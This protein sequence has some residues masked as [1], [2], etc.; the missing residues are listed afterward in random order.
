MIRVSTIW[1]ATHVRIM[2]LRS[3]VTFMIR[4]RRTRPV[5]RPFDR[6][7]TDQ[8]DRVAPDPAGQ[9]NRLVVLMHVYYQDALPRLIELLHAIPARFDLVITNSSG[10]PLLLPDDLPGELDDLRILDVRN[11]GRDIW[12]MVQV[13]NDG[14]I[15]KHDLVLKVHTKRSAWRDRHSLA[16]TGAEWNE[17]LLEATLGGPGRIST[18]LDVFARDPSLG[19]VTA[20]GCVLGPERWG[21]NHWATRILLRRMGLP[22]RTYRLRFPS[23]SIYWARA[24]ILRKLGQATLEECDFEAEAGQVDGTT[25]HAIERGIGYLCIDAGLRM[26][27]TDE[28]SAA[29]I[30]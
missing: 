30:P 21:Q 17:Q 19:L 11:H 22:M 7:P 15:D 4:S 26:A 5:I 16:G 12:P 28:L 23:G 14:L 13:I 24:S 2:L 20:P 27:T 18:I 10:A 6:A 8:R 1:L 25:A 29:W 3:P 9:P